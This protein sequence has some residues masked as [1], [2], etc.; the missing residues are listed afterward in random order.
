MDDLMTPEERA[1]VISHRRVEP[2]N[3]YMSLAPLGSRVVV[4]GPGFATKNLGWGIAFAA[5]KVL[6]PN[7]SGELS[8]AFL[9]HEF[10]RAGV[11]GELVAAS[12]SFDLKRY[13]F[14]GELRPYLQLGAGIM[15]F[16]GAPAAEGEPMEKRVGIL[17]NPGVGLDLRL[18]DSLYL[19]I[20]SV[21]RTMLPS[22]TAAVTGERALTAAF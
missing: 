5:G 6:A 2:R 15:G 1:A 3:Y 17:L 19:G 9:V 18:T 20:R 10:D 11:D 14:S 4:H 8:L 16:D 12:F 22:V 21:L 7:I 13:F